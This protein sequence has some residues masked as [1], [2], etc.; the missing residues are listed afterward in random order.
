M[1]RTVLLVHDLLHFVPL[2]SSSHITLA[3]EN[4]FLRK[5]LAFYP[6]TEGQAASPGRCHPHDARRVGAGDRLATTPHRGPNWDA[7]A[8]PGDP[9]TR[10]RCWSALPCDVEPRAET[11]H[12]RLRNSPKLT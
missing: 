3:A 11:P 10:R 5:Q 9:L 1:I 4:L 2:I 12:K 8:P 7:R 6:G